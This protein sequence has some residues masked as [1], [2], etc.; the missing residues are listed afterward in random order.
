MGRDAS[1]STRVIMENERL[2][3]ALQQTNDTENPEIIGVQMEKIL[4]R[5]IKY[6]LSSSEITHE[7]K[8]NRMFVDVMI[9]NHIY[10]IQ[11]QN[12]NAIRHKLDKLLPTYA[13][14]IVYPAARIKQL[15]SINEAGE[16]VKEQ[17]SPKKGT[18]F[19]ILVEMYKIKS[20]LNDSNLDFKILYF[21]MDEYRTIVPKRHFRSRGYQR[22][23]QVPTNLV[24]EINLRTIADYVKLLISYDIKTEFTVKDFA[25]LS[26]LS[27]SKAST[28]VN[29]L[30]SLGAIENIGKVG[31]ANLWKITNM[32]K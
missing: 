8:I 14:T 19:S 3:K 9:N 25:K 26:K 10:E 15:Y 20:Y 22:F 11:T 18:P 32:T 7:V 23:K 2:Q 17:R 5:T 16:L 21:D 30:A 13:I 1:V 24:S 6:Y 29:V 31:R 28:A 27:Q 12:F 4:H